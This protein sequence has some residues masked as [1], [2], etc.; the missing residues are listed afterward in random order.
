VVVWSESAAAGYLLAQGQFLRQ[1][2]Q[3]LQA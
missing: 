3:T 2:L 1:A